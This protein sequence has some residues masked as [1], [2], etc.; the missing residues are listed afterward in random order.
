[1]RPSRILWLLVALSAIFVVWWKTTPHAKPVI[2]E[3]KLETHVFADNQLNVRIRNDGRDGWVLVSYK[4]T[5]TSSDLFIRRRG[6]I[7]RWWSEDDSKLDVVPKEQTTQGGPW[8]CCTFLKAGETKAVQLELPQNNSSHTQL[9]PFV[10]AV[11]S[12][13]L[14]APVK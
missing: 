12:P 3:S 2:V 8:E 5:H 14:L 6:R 9:G 7:E 4:T 11:L 1:M 10:S 13:P